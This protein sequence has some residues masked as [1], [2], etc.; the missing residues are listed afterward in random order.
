MSQ[1]PEWVPQYGAMSFAAL[2]GSVARG[3]SW[4]GSDGKL[5]MTRVVTE[6][7]TALGL[8]MGMMALGEWLHWDVKVLVG[9]A[10]FAGWLG[11]AAVSDMVLSRFSLGGSKRD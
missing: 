9:L 6:L 7:A 3:R 11:P 4:Q 10:V 1:V 5:V 2:V 8:S